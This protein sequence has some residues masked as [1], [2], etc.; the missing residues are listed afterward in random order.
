MPLA[1]ATP[2]S[3]KC[4]DCTASVPDLDEHRKVR[5]ERPNCPAAYEDW[6]W[7]ETFDEPENDFPGDDYE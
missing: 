7:G 1:L 4:P 3:T 5:V 6:A 2:A